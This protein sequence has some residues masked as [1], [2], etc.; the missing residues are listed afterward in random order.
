MLKG[1]WKEEVENR[2]GS[3]SHGQKIKIRRVHQ[4]SMCV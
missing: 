2:D 4:Q 1:V 3:V